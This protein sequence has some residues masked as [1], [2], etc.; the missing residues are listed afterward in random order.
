MTEPTPVPESTE[1]EDRVSVAVV[2]LGAMGSR[3]A[4]RLLEAGHDI[5]VWNGRRRR[6]TRSRSWEPSSSPPHWLNP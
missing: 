1:E 5:L 6:R 4:G 2:G 3:V